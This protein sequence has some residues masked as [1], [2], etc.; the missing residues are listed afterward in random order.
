MLST[1][2]DV[3][4]EAPLRRSLSS[5]SPRSRSAFTPLG[6]TSPRSRS[7]PPSLSPFSTRCVSNPCS[8]RFVAAA[9]PATPPPT[10]SAF[11]VTGNFIGVRGFI[12]DAFRTAIFTMSFAFRRAPA[13]SSL[14]TQESIFLTFAIS[15]RYLFRP[16]R[17][18]E[19][20][21]VG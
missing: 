11:W 5:P 1:S 2:V 14:W 19:P 9:M 8:A 3:W 6:A 16:A 10:T 4:T 20:W 12:L 7:M 15:K 17:S 18:R 21:K 13:L